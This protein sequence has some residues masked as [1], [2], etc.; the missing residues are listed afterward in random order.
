[1]S[2]LAPI[3]I[4]IQ[5]MDNWMADRITC[6]KIYVWIKAR[7]IVIANLFAWCCGMK[8]FAGACSSSHET[9]SNVQRTHF[10]STIF[11][12]A[13]FHFLVFFQH[14]LYLALPICLHILNSSSD[15]F[16]SLLVLFSD[17]ACSFTRRHH[18]VR[19]RPTTFAS[20]PCTP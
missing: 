17:S 18:L 3:N 6:H 14:F 19:I 10:I 4:F 11:I 9:G 7:K 16:H 5:Y 1:M 13:L 8:Q 2:G 20:V 12:E 15:K